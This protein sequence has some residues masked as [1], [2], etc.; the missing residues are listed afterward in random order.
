MKF[1][2]IGPDVG[3]TVKLAV[4]PALVPT[5]ITIDPDPVAPLVSV[6]VAVTCLLPAVVYTC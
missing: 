5:T 6:A 1:V 3:F 4:G 2:V